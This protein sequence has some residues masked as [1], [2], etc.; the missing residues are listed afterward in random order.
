MKR[1]SGNYLYNTLDENS[2]A[3]CTPSD[4]SCRSHRTMAFAPISTVFFGFLNH[5]ALLCPC[6]IAFKMKQCNS[7]E[8]IFNLA[9]TEEYPDRIGR[10]RGEI[11]WPQWSGLRGDTSGNQK[12]ESKIDVKF[13]VRFMV[14][15]SI[16]VTLLLKIWSTDGSNQ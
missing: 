4:D 5:P 13:L 8:I 11:G 2:D 12:K 9:F 15:S 1:T 14:L 3:I 6:G 16:V 10:N 7:S